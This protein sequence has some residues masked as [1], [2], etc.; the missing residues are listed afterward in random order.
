M[1]IKS[2]YN[3]NRRDQLVVHVRKHIFRQAMIMIIGTRVLV[4][5]YRCSS[6]SEAISVN[7]FKND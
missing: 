2:K 7:T 5:V 3:M 6:S 4:F 1:F